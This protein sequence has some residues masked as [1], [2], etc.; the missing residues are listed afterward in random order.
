MSKGLSLAKIYINS[1]Y[2]LS[3]FIRDLKYNKKNA[4]KT[5]GFI[6]LIIFSLSGMFGMYLYFNIKMYELL[7]KINQQGAV[8]TL[9]VVSSSILTL[10]FGI[11]TVLANYFYNQ[12]GD[13]ILALPIKKMDL[14]FAKFINAYIVEFIVTFIFMGVGIGVYGIKSGE[15]ILFYLVSIISTIFIPLIPLSICYFLI[16]PL[17]KYGNLTKKKDFFMILG[18]FFGVI[19]ALIYQVL[20]NKLAST[21][22]GSED[23]IKSLMKE[24]GLID[25]VGRI[26]YPSIWISN[27]I[28]N[29]KSLSGILYLFAFVLLSILIVYL[30]LLTTSNLYYSSI[31]GSSEVTKKNREIKGEEIDKVFKKRSLLSSLFIREMKLM[32]REPIYF[33]N[34]PFVVLLLPLIFAIMF[35]VNKQSLGP[36]DTLIKQLDNVKYL[37]LISTGIIMFMGSTTSI[38]STCISREGSGIYVLKSLPIRP[39]DIIK[40]KFLHGA[41]FG[42]IASI[43]VSVGLLYLKVP[44]YIIFLSVVIGNLY[45]FVIYLVGIILELNWPKLVWDNPQKPMKQNI[46]A[47][48]IIFID[49]ALIGI[50]YLITK[51]IPHS[52]LI[53]AFFMIPIILLLFVYIY[54]NKN[55]EGLYSRL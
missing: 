50:N 40:A 55:V 38:T 54:L 11:L 7:K 13:I 51:T 9:A 16:I 23:I 27:G 15:G 43:I 4:V 30:L 35:T 39:I 25:V 46:N 42:F 5:I 45:L 28:L 6:L 32:N 29:Y 53:L 3:R 2:G 22:A 49:F 24:N 33:L 10:M 12:E 37:L 48:F 36:I 17:M 44:F 8:I 14:L 18:G 34:G 1:T 21:N 20:I 41:F 52:I 19:I 26:Y 47:V 31:I